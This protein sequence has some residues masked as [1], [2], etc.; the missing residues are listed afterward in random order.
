MSI[1]FYTILPYSYQYAPLLLP[2]AIGNG[3]AA[4]GAYAALDVASGGPASAAGSKLLKHPLI[5]GGGIG[6]FTGFVAPLYLYGPIYHAL[7]GLEGISDA[8]YYLT[9][10]HFTGI[11][12]TTGFAAGVAMYPILHYPIYGI[13]SVPWMNLTG[14]VLLGT[15]AALFYIYNPD[16]EN[17]MPLPEGC[18]VA[19]KDVPLL[20]SVIRYD[21]EKDDFGTYSLTTNEYVGNGDLKEKGQQMA[22]TVRKYQQGGWN[23]QQYTFDHQ[24]LAVL[25]NF[26]D[27]GIADRFEKNVV[28]VRDVR[29]LQDYEEIMYRTDW[30]VKCMMERNR[31][32]KDRYS[33]SMGARKKEASDVEKLKKYGIVSDR[34]CKRRLK[35]IEST[36]TAVELLM[37]NRLAEK[38]IREGG[39]QS[40]VSSFMSNPLEKIVSYFS[41]EKKKKDD[42]SAL[43]LETWIRKRCPGILLYRDEEEQAGLSGQ[44]VEAQLETLRW[45]GPSYS[46]TLEHW[47]EVCG[48]ERGEKLRNGILITTSLLA[49]YWLQL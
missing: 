7:Y 14:A 4:G 36:S 38:N 45:E 34:E 9:F 43:E 8:L 11:S 16:D 5:A 49:S 48:Q 23:T 47:R 32:S 35:N 31:A 24:V 18:F 10:P 28:K 2:C 46:D 39:A 27:H 25:G 17:V 29:E 1:A 15:S 22:Q 20:N 40:N 3:I 13:P 26:F 6:A 42:P 19:K 33:Y 12:V 41:E 37:I 44:S 30:V 21:V